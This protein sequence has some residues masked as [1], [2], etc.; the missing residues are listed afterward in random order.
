M[1]IIPRYS[2]PSNKLTCDETLR[3]VKM[4]QMRMSFKTQPTV[5]YFSFIGG[6]FALNVLPHVLPQYI[7]KYFRQILCQHIHR[8]SP[9]YIEYIEWFEIYI[10]LSLSF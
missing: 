10:Y 7:S 3:L 1:Y 5:Y 2:Q 6:Y 4:S 8:D 9:H